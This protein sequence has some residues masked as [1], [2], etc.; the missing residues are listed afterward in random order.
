M[1]R[2][3]A[4][5]L[6]PSNSVRSVS[7]KRS[8]SMRVR[9]CASGRGRRPIFFRVFLSIVFT[10]PKLYYI[11]YEKVKDEIRPARGEKS[12]VRKTS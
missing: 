5:A 4:L 3:P 7:V 11:K 12:Q 8:V 1:E 6:S 10:S 2:H 9:L